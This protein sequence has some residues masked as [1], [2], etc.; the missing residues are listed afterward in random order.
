MTGTGTKADPYIVETWPEI[1]QTVVQNDVYIQL[2][3][4]IDCKELGAITVTTE[5]GY[6]VY[7]MNCAELN[8]MGYAI[9]NAYFLNCSSIFGGVRCNTIKNLKF[10]NIYLSNSTLFVFRSDHPMYYILP[11]FI[12]C[13][14]SI[15]AA[16]GGTVFFDIT[17]HLYAAVFRRCSFYVYGADEHCMFMRRSSFADDRMPM[18]LD[19]CVVELRG[20]F[21]TILSAQLVNTYVFGEVTVSYADDP[22]YNHCIRVYNT[23]SYGYYTSEFMKSNSI[24]DLTVHNNTGEQLYA[25][26]DSRY[27]YDNNGDSHYEVDSL[28][29]NTEVLENFAYSATGGASAFKRCT[30]SQIHNETYL[31]GQGFNAETLINDRYITKES[32]TCEWYG[33]NSEEKAYIDTGV[34][35]SSNVKIMSEFEFSEAKGSFAI[36]A[37]DSE[38]Y[39]VAHGTGNGQNIDDIESIQVN[40]GANS[41]TYGLVGTKFHCYTPGTT[42]WGTQNEFPMIINGQNYGG[43]KRYGMDGR[44]YHVSIWDSNTTLIRDYYPAYD[45]VTHEYG[46]YDKV[47]QTFHG[48]DTDLPFNSGDEMPFKFVD[49]VIIHALSSRLHRLGAFAGS[50]SLVRVTIP[51]TVKKIGRYAFRNT[52]LQKVKIA[53]DCTYYDTSFPRGCVIE[54]Y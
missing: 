43:T 47:T 29:V 39:G 37:Y 46:M 11:T 17:T 28:F 18:L 48:S 50:G 31:R 12:D 38:G 42:W 52:Q 27:Y 16:R 19:D 32:L 8:G 7:N 41:Y 23:G 26:I 2:G 14:F 33:P 10:K 21:E 5:S 9:K 25:Y 13:D 44:I 35:N 53:S 4:D 6:G 30:T 40:I 1:T 45:N 20:I 22:N 49:G 15:E 36:G 54:H 24:I 51:P 3:H 34:K